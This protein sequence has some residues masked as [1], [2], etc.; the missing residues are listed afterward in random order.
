MAVEVELFDD[1]DVVAR[2]A[3]GALDRDARA[4]LFERLDWFRL[5]ERHCPPP[6]KLLVIRA[7]EGDGRA[8][9]FMKV[10]G[11]KVVGLANWYSL[12][13][14]AVLECGDR[15]GSYRLAEALIAGIR[16]YRPRIAAVE[17]YPLHGGDPL[18]LS[19]PGKFWLSRVAP[20][21]V[22]WSMNTYDLDFATYWAS[23]PSRLRNTAER[24]A[25]AAALDIRVHTGFSEEA[26]ADYERVYQSSWKPE[27]G[28][29]ALV[30]AL[31]EMEGDAGNLRLGIAK[32][33]GHPVAAQLWLTEGRLATIHKLAYAEEAKALAPGTILS[34]EMFRHALDVDRVN[35]IS[36]GLGDDAYKADWID[37]SR[38]VYRLVAYDMLSPRGL[39]WAGKLAASKLVRRGRSG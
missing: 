36:F 35:G 33:D 37:H 26:W 9:L 16:R 1:L 24:K 27:E 3:A 31:A 11:H 28:S 12:N 8:W 10:D 29:P 23:R 39:W 14:G 30:R 19:F 17:L 25:K 6:G 38:P 22:S 15:H 20:A 21:S 2:D 7:R 34:M 4:C 32:K 18:S 5:V 13:F